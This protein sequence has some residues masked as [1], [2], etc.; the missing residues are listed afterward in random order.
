[1]TVTIGDDCAIA[2]RLTIATQIYPLMPSLRPGKKTLEI[3]P[4]VPI[5]R[6]VMIGEKVTILPDVTV[7][8][9][10]VLGAESVVTKDVGEN[11]EWVGNPA[12]FVRHIE[13]GQGDTIDWDA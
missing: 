7:G 13:R 4:P 1:M 3:A 2:N 6:T 12:R 11:E 10:A 9:G 8:D 5:G